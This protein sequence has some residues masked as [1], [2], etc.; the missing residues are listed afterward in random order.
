MLHTGRPGG[1]EFYIS[2]QDNV[3]NHGPGSQGSATEADSC[4]GK[5]FIGERVVDRI[6]RQ[7]GAAPPSGFVDKTA[8][9]IR[10]PHVRIM[11]TEEVNHLE[12]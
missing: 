2:T 6:K 5:I 1:P 12:T 8:N 10:I 3:E 4:F 11:T 7:P 9:F